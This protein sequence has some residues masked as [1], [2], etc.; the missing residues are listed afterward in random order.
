VLDPLYD[1]VARHRY[2]LFGRSDECLVPA[3][4]VRN[5]FVD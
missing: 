5:R 1:L 4:H 2:R 3:R